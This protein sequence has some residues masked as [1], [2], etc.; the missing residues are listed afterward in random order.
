MQF[1]RKPKSTQ[2]LQ[3]LVSTRGGMLAVAGLVAVLAGTML[4]FFLSQYRQ[5]VADSEN[6]VKVLVAKNLI[7]KGSPGDV[8]A[9]KGL[10]QTAS[11]KQGQ[12]NDGAITDPATLKGKVAASDIY[13]GQQL[14]TSEFAGATNSL[15]NK[16]SDFERAIS[17]PL[18]SAH[19]MIGD[20]QSGDHVDVLAGFNEEAGLGSR[21]VLKTVMQNALVLRAPDH[22]KGNLGANATQNVVLRAPDEKSWQVAFSSEFGKV[23]IVLRP[24]AGAE[25]TKPSI[26]TLEKVLL[27]VKP[28]P[29]QRL[30]KGGRR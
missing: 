8:I 9:S 2:E 26:V 18:D 21:P 23:W 16:V 12:R 30:I 1:V 17:I 10:F 24:K 20:V 4:L 5:R 27:G 14:T 15:T 13:P 28:I 22:A 29:V 6:T 7:E 11:I 25:Q 19:G 3:R